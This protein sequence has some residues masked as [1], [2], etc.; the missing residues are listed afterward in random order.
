M[1]E[2]QQHIIS[3]P[4]HQIAKPVRTLE[5]LLKLY[6]EGHRNFSGSD[7][8]GATVDILNNEI[9]NLDLQDIIIRSSNLKAIKFSHQY[10]ALKVNLTGADLSECNLQGADL[11]SCVLD[12]CNFTQSDLRN[13]N[14]SCQSCRGSD[15]VKVKFLNV[16]TGSGTDFTASDFTGS[17]F[18]STK[19]S[20]KFSYSKFYGVDFQKASF[21]NFEAN[22]ADFSDANLQDVDLAAKWVNFY[23]SYYN[24]QTKFSSDFDPISRGMEII[25]DSISAE[26]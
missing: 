7:L 4:E 16:S 23:Y 20:G 22:G 18:R 11:S 5:A 6:A 13:V 12:Q 3:L 2:E 24:N 25:E 19:L 9:E 21:T 26:D 15:F 17:D 10:S 8:R 14:L 1:I